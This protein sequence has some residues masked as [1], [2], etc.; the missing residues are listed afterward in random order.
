VAS[1]FFDPEDGGDTHYTASYPRRRYSSKLHSFVEFGILTAVV[2][3]SSIFWDVIGSSAC[4]LLHA[5]FLLGL[6]FNPEDGGN[7][8]LQ[9]T[10]WLSLDYMAFC[11]RR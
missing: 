5:C 6:L 8:F 1:R 10:G 7:I 11:S 3:K 9:N 2:M 4:C